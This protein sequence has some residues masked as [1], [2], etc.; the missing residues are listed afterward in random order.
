MEYQRFPPASPPASSPEASA[1]DDLTQALRD[2]LTIENTQSAHA[3]DI[4]INVAEALLTGLQ[5]I[6]HA[7]RDL[8][9]ANAGT[10]MGA[11]EVL[12]VEIK[13]G[14][15]RIAEGLEAVAEAI[16]EVEL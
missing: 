9:L 16:K 1:L 8:G 3:L 15:E 5:A 10:P 13:A 14:S 7:L 2:T 12:S 6:A 11:L 4:E